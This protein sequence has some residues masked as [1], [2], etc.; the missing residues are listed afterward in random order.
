L[1]VPLA[2][3][4]K[5]LQEAVEAKLLREAV[6]ILLEVDLLVQWDG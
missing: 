1:A 5:P 6:A 4:A 2:V 3:V